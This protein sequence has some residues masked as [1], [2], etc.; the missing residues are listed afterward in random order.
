MNNREE[1]NEKTPDNLFAYKGSN[2]KNQSEKTKTGWEFINDNA[3]II[4]KEVDANK[5][6]NSDTLFIEFYF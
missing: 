1:L 2:Q 5:I 3:P 6:F 4:M